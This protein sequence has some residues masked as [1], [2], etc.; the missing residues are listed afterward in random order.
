MARKKDK[1]TKPIFWDINPIRKIPALYRLIYGERSN[2]KTYGVLKYCIEDWWKNGRQFG[3][4][5]RWPDDIKT[6][7]M[8]QLF[9]A[10][11]TN[12]EI[13]KITDGQWNGVKYQHGKFYLIATDGDTIIQHD[14]PFCH[15]FAISSMEH[16]KSIAYPEIGNILFDEFI[17]RGAYIQDEF[18]LFMNVLSSIIRERS[19]VDIW[20]LGNTVS[21][22]CP[23]FRE[24]GLR[25][26]KNQK[27]GTI[28]TYCYS[29]DGTEMIV[30]VEYTENLSAKPSDKYFLFDNPKMDMIT[31]GAWELAIYPHI[32][33]EYNIRQVMYTFFI[34]YREEIL[35]CEVVDGKNG[36][37]IYV[38]QKTT[39]LQNRPDDL[40]YTIEP[41]SNRN[42]RMIITQPELKIEKKILSL[43][44]AERICFQD[45][46]VGEL[47][48]DYLKWCRSHQLIK[49]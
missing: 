11:T 8:Q 41:S 14:K 19:D 32:F 17:S 37:F 13:S 42:Y 20:M 24:M 1:G 36:V 35:Q 49:R 46:E 21:K 29:K 30:A 38:H 3:Y 28:D 45:N 26:I 43:I 39:P 47:F 5:R 16:Q 34:V 12:G 23:Y 9:S 44:I 48:N 7:N 22:E 31:G 6:R 18:S 2:G 40:V 4:L 27:P 10:L 33:E 15:T 25:H